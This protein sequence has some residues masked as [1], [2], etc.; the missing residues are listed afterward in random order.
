MGD[1]EF[2][3]TAPDGNLLRCEEWRPESLARAAVVF[4]HGMSGWA[5]D[6]QPVG[7]ML[8]G[9]RVA[10]F[11]LNLRGQ[12][13]DPH[14]RDRGMDLNL[15]HIEKDVMAFIGFVK[16]QVPD[17]PV[18]LFGESMG[19]LVS[20]WLLAQSPVR[21]QVAGAILS[22]PVVAL[23]KPTHPILQTLLQGA[24]TLVPRLRFNPGRFVTSKRAPLQLT[25][26]TEW[27][28][29]RRLTEQ[30]IRV[31]S[32]RFLWRLGQLITSSSTLAPKVQVPLLVLAAGKDVFVHADRI[33]E[34]FDLIGSPDKTLHTYHES[35]HLLWWDIKRDQVLEDIRHWLEER[36]A[37]GA[38]S[39]SERD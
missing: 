2:L 22:V 12:G 9:E 6:F 11:A 16:E 35:C 18:F 33:A 3:W 24:A 27:Q 20:M 28:E 4:L 37:Q 34:W 15:E 39:T 1:M 30:H 32:V 10:A 25:H 5:K 29:N 31:F 8:A 21:S 38:V 17:R 36:L 14:P 19:S 13:L 26:D 23:K 7:E